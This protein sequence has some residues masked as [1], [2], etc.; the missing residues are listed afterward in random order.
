MNRREFNKRETVR[1]IRSVFLSLYAKG[2]ID[3]LTIHALCRECGIAKSTF[4]LYF[5]DKYAVLDA[6]EEELLSGLRLICHD[7]SDC[8]MDDVQNGRPLVRA[9][10]AIRF[11]R[12]RGDEFRTLLGR[13]GDPRLSYK[14]KKDIES[15]FMERFRAE[16]QDDASAAIACTIFS[17]ALIGLYTH[18][19]FDAP[20]IS[21]EKFSIILGNRLKYSLYDFRAFAT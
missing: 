13:Y 9:K 14:W 17:S 4:Y 11:L 21:E 16:M 2:G 15:S 5:E 20:D 7:L 3:S 12:S 6:I 1:H 19:L 8:D 10:E 18:F